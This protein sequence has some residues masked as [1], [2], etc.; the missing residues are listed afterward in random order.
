VTGQP[1]PAADPD[2][3]AHVGQHRDP[4][5]AARAVR[6]FRFVRPPGATSILLVRH[7]ESMPARPDV[8]FSLVDGQGDPE[9]APAGR[10]QADQLAQRLAPEP[11]A[12]IYVTTLRRTVETAAPLA[13]RLGIVPVVEAELREVHLGDWEGGLFRIRVA[14]GHPIAKRFMAEQR[15]DV[16]PGAEPSEAFAARVRR[17]LAAVAERHPDQL[18]VV[19]THGG[20]IGQALA[21]ATASSPFAFNGADNG[22]ISHLVITSDRWL[23]RTFNDSAH[24]RLGFAL[25]AEPLT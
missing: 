14:E 19:F 18:V 4:D 11:I 6:Q 21:E 25:A 22:S 20:V 13:S 23:V 2:G 1:H 17:A 3:S 12:A 15:W 5:P 10:E 8:P 7:G 9:L 24:L 16:I